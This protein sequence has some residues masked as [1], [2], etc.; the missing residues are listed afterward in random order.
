MQIAVLEVA[1][2]SHT[3][4]KKRNVPQ[5]RER[6]RHRA[7]SAENLDRREGAD[8]ADPEGNHVRKR[9]DRDADRRLGH[10]V[11]HPLWHGQLHRRSSPSRKH[12]K[13]VVDSNAC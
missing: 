4:G 9:G 3:A 7:V 12:D 6:D 10:H 5:V 11:P 2:H 1:E 13:C 8:D